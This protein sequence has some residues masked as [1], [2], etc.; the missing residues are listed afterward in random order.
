MTGRRVALC[1]ACGGATHQGRCRVCG[2]RREPEPR[3]VV[4]LQLNSGLRVWCNDGSLK[5]W[6]YPTDQDV[7]RFRNKAN[8]DAIARHMHGRVVT[9]RELARMPQ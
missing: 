9:E 8:A 4:I 1:A 6:G 7:Q 3:Y 5:Y 2:H